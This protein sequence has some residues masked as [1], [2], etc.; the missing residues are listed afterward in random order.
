MRRL[1]LDR[2]D[3]HHL[4]RVVH[5]PADEVAIKLFTK[6]AATGETIFKLLIV[7]VIV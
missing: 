5:R 2:A 6:E 7:L 4:G 1:D 3:L